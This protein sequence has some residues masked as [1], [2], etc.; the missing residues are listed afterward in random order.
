M[1]TE[2]M[3]ACI[4]KIME[5]VWTERDTQNYGELMVAAH[6]LWGLLSFDMGCEHPP[7]E[8]PQEGAFEF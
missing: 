4:Y 6:N 7:R 2:Q 5:Q 3:T 8:L 1:N